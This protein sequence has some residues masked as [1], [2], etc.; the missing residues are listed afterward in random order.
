ME[1][2]IGICSI[3]G[4]RVIA[5]IGPWLSVNPPPPPTCE[6][7]G[8]V[9]AGHRRIVPMEP[10]F[11]PERIPMPPWPIGRPTY[12]WFTEVYC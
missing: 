4:G 2:V 8:A 5:H 1:T 10:P 3:C 6:V 11:G 9:A 7:C 12:P